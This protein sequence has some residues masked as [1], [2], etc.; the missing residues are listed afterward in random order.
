MARMNMMPTDAALD[1]FRESIR[2]IARASWNKASLSEATV[3]QVIVLRLLMAAGFDIWNPLEVAAEETNAAKNR[4]DLIVSCGEDK[5]NNAFV[6]EL[7]RRDVQIDDGSLGQALSYA[8]HSG[9]RW[10]ILTNGHT[11]VIA[12]EKKSG[13]YPD[14]VV[15]RIDLS[16]D[17]AEDLHR[18]LERSVWVSGKFD[19]ALKCVQIALDERRESAT[20]IK[21]KTPLLEMFML[22]FTIT[23]RSKAAELMVQMG[24]LSDLE[25]DILVG[26][27]STGLPRLN[28]FI[29]VAKPDTKLLKPL[30]E[31]PANLLGTELYCRGR[32]AYAIAI[33]LEDGSLEIQPGSTAVAEFVESAKQSPGRIKAR[34]ELVAVGVL[35]LRPDGLLEFKN[36]VHYESSSGA[37]FAILGRP[38]QGPKEWK[39]KDGRSYH[40]LSHQRP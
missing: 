29:P 40:E 22:E 5:E 2:D 12:D 9:I 36:P 26:V 19:N 24:K 16:E 3:R 33:L 8:G 21:E 14:R 28:S 7:K 15:L 31:S 34:E 11:W 39:T 4:P 1:Q 23:D 38:S 10:A 30:K 6:L 35:V 18:L 32:G 27:D 13:P 20:I 25:R 37:A 17:N